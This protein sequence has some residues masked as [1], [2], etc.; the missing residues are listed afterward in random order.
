MTDKYEVIIVGGITVA[1][2]YKC[3]NC[4]LIRPYNQITCSCKPKP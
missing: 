1:Q 2:G 4:G 3:S